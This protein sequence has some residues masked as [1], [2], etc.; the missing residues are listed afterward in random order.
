MLE[1]VERYNGDIACLEMQIPQRTNLPKYDIGVLTVVEGIVV[2][3]L[4]GVAERIS[5]F[6]QT[7]S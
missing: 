5:Y 4:C 1:V 2:I 3:M 7:A 6:S